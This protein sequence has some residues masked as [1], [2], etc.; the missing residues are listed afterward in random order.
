MKFFVKYCFCAILLI[1]HI[2]PLFAQDRMVKVFLDIDSLQKGI[3][4]L[5]V[6][7][8]DESSMRVRVRYIGDGKAKFKFKIDT[9]SEVRIVRITKKRGFA[10]AERI[11]GYIEPGRE[12]YVKGKSDKYGVRYNTRGGGRLNTEF[13]EAREHIYPFLEMESRYEKKGLSL[14]KN[15]RD[16]ALE[17][18]RKSDSVR[19]KVIPMQRVAFAKNHLDYEI[20]SYYLWQSGVSRDS[21]QLYLESIPKDISQTY[22][23]ACLARYVKA[24][25]ET[26]MGRLAPNFTS[27]TAA[28]GLIDIH[29]LALK[30]EYVILDFWGTWCPP[31]MLEM[32]QLKD[33]YE[34]YNDRIEIVGIACKDEEK[35][36]R[37]II[38]A[39][40][41]NWHNVLNSRKNNIADLYG[42]MKFPSKV[43]L[44]RNA[45]VV[46]SDLHGN[47]NGEVGF[48]DFMKQALQSSLVK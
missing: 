18:F 4:V 23:G 41:L 36:W 39:N 38:E 32:P 44:D 28:G 16:Q 43:V 1:S 19:L 11:I 42:V 7:S 35:K 46:Y 33:L 9:V 29:N 6:K 26:S 20:S 24:V 10:R 14:W 3:Y 30:S 13:V 8:I 12:L 15:D 47:G 5:G 22:Y 17:Y 2:F 48:Y 37:R 31:C 25:T 27:G 21:L 34:M 45:R 40:D